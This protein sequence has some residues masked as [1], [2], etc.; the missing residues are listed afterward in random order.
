VSIEDVIII[1]LVFIPVV[2]DELCRIVVGS[3]VD[4]MIFELVFIPV[5][6]YV[7]W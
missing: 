5:V 7:L 3:I 6:M 2:I 4:V 1:E